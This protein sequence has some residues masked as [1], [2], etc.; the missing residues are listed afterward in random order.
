MN[1]LWFGIRTFGNVSAF[2][3]SASPIS[4]FFAQ[5]KCG[6]RGETN[7]G[8]PYGCRLVVNRISCHRWWTNGSIATWPCSSHLTPQRGRCL[9][10]KEDLKFDSTNL[11][12]GSSLTG[13]LAARV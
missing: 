3:V 10:I 12:G 7:F 11:S 4:L 9:D 5:D 13:Q 6:Q 8:L 2:I 1:P